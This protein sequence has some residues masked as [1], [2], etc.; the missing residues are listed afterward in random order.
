MRRKTTEN[1]KSGS[2]DIINNSAVLAFVRIL[3]MSVSIVQTMILS[4]ALTK[5][6]YG[7]YSQALLVISFV[8]PFFSL[9]LENSVNYF[10]NKTL[11]ERIK[12]RF[13]HTIFSL[14]ICCGVLCS[15][16]VLLFRNQIT[17]YFGNPAILGIIV[18]IAFRPCLQN[19]IALYQPLF[20]SSGYARTIA[21]RNLIISLAQIGI[22]GGISC[23]AGDIKMIFL[24]L[25]LLDLAQVS[26]FAVIYQK[27]KFAISIFKA[28][29]SLTR[30][31]LRYALPMLLA[32]SIGTISLNMDKLMIG[33]IMSTEDYALYSNVSKELPF[34]FVVSSFT[35]VVSPLIIQYLNAGDYKR[36]KTIWSGYL[37]MGYK[38]TWPLCVGAAVMAPEMIEFLYSKAYLNSDGITVFRI[39]TV[40]SM[41]RF[42]YFGMVP[43]ALGKTDIVLKYSGISCGMNLCLN[44]L[45]YLLLGMPGPAVATVISL[46]ASAVLYFRASIKMV[47]IPLK[48]ILNLQKMTV[49]L[50][51]MVVCGFMVRGIVSAA[52][53]YFNN[54]LIN[55][56]FGYL[57][58]NGV[59][60]G[61]NIKNLKN[62]FIIMKKGGDERCF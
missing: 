27:R 49:F 29:F 62:L 3:T 31:I 1:K 15:F 9:G 45:L 20:I 58:F 48:E 59:I 56:V 17:G 55:L 39:Y 34:A 5:T 18:Y 2:M 22:I 6:D 50:I 47:K 21:T 12:E 19:L 25:L 44:Y 30:E 24:C 61:L 52:E 35:A 10:Y 36:F 26:C 57:L 28:D 42:S 33:G 40:A 14:S 53:Q 46:I 11:E 38:I 60:F 54:T 16:C 8:S 37:E 13:I 41:M 4:R 51:E 23:F 7:T 32:T 43:T